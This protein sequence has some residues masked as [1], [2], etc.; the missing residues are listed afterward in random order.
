MPQ[1]DKTSAATNKITAYSYN[2][3]L[4]MTQCNGAIIT[5]LRHYRTSKYLVLSKCLPYFLIIPQLI[6]H[7]RSI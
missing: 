3:R 2:L 6:M 4:F 5:I 7:V 1:M